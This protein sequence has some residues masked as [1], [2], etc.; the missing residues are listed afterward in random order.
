MTE[1]LGFFAQMVDAVPVEFQIFPY[2]R[3]EIE[4]SEPFLVDGEAIN[5]VVER[6]NARGLDMVID[7]E[8]QTEGGDYSS[9]DGQA[10][11][12][13]WIKALENRG[14]DGLWAR[15]EW[16][17]KARQYLSNREYRYFSPVFLV[18]KG[19]RK[20]LELLRVALTNAPRLNWI[21]PI[22]AKHHNSQE[23]DAMDFLKK[24]AKRLGLPETA[25][26]TEVEAA[27]EKAR[28]A[29]PEFLKISAKACGIAE[30][31][32]NWW[33][34]RSRLARS[35]RPRRNGRK[36][37]LSRTRRASGSLSPRPR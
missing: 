32:T 13:G 8:H 36:P 11:A 35:P 12:A 9:P 30:T 17:E 3:V 10:P 33:P 18:S 37:M 23:G 24:I 2:G 34:S 4:G 26:E 25:T 31:A 27:L 6:F 14:P 29:A 7:C 1:R 20:L 21:R 5:A 28:S 16:T 15:V 22:V 19:A